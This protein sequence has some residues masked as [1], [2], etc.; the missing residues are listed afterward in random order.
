MSA[1]HVPAMRRRLEH[2]ARALDPAAAFPPRDSTTRSPVPAVKGNSRLLWSTWVTATAV[3]LATPA[4][5]PPAAAAARSLVRPSRDATSAGP[6]PHAAAQTCQS[7]KSNDS[8]ST[9]SAQEKTNGGDGDV[10]RRRMV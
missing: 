2:D 9:A 5:V 6:T 4:P 7:G 10:L 8:A 1:W 3:G